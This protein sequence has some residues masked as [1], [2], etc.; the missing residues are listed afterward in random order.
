MVFIFKIF[1]RLLVI[2]NI[3]VDIIIR[4]VEAGGSFFP[5]KA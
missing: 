3:M 1:W 2:V 4:I 5:T